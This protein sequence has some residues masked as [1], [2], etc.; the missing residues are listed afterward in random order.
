MVLGAIL[1]IV[2]GVLYWIY[3]DMRTD[4]VKEVNAYVNVPYFIYNVLIHTQV[5]ECF[6]Q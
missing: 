4:S 3:G 6:L 2:G 1:L 5:T